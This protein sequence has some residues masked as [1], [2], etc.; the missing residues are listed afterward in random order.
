[1]DL[2]PGRG[3][4]KSVLD[5][6]RSAG[7]NPRACAGSRREGCS[8]RVL[9]FA[10]V[11]VVPLSIAAGCGGRQTPSTGGAAD[12][13]V[14][15][16]T[17]EVTLTDGGVAEIDRAAKDTKNAVVLVEFWSMATEPSPNLSLV[18]NTRGE[19]NQVL[20]EAL[21]KDKVAWH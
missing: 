16:Q 9:F 8:M 21:G 14:P 15:R 10:G 18:G 1:M 19:D 17:S 11:L 12:G 4:G 20:G 5:T 3:W 6:G 7:D 13:A 2:A